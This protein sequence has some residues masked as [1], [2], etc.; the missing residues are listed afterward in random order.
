LYRIPDGIGFSATDLAV[1]SDCAHR[2]ALELRVVGG[3][4]KRPGRNALQEQLLDV[5]GLE[6]EKRALAHLEATYGAAVTIRSGPTSLERAAEETADAMHSGAPLIYQAVF[7]DGKWQGRPDFLVKTP[8]PSKLGAFSYEVVDAKLARELRARSVLQLLVYGT[9]L[10]RVQGTTPARFGVVPMTG[11]LDVEW[12]RT[13]DF[14]AYERRVRTSFEAFVA[15]G[16]GD[17]TYPEPVEHCDVCPW[18]KRCDSRRREDDHLSLVAGMTGRQR[19]RLVDGGVERV[20]ELGALA[21]ELRIEG[22]RTETLARL[23]EQARLQVTGRSAG[24]L[25]YELLLEAEAGTG[26]ESLPERSPGDVFLDLEGDPHLGGKGLDY[27]FGLLE[28][29]EEDDYFGGPPRKGPPK[30]HAFWATT[31]AEERRAFEAVV[32]RMRARFEQYPGLH[33]YHFGHRENDALKRLANRHGTRVDV[34]DDWLSRHTL[35]DLHRAVRQGLRA[36]VESYSLKELEPLWAFERKTEVRDAKWA[37][38]TFTLALETGAPPDDDTE[39]QR[40]LIQSYNRE[41][42]E[43]AMHLRDWLETRRIELAAAS[44]RVLKRPEEPKQKTSDDARDLKLATERVRKALVGDLADDDDGLRARALRLLA[45]LLDWHARESKAEYWEFFRARD[46]ALED[47]LE[48]RSVLANPHLVGEMEQVAQ[49][50]V[51]RYEFPE[52]EHGI[53]VDTSPIDPDREDETFGKVLVVG[54]DHLHVKRGKKRPPT[55]PSR[56]VPPKPLPTTNQRKCLLALGES[57]AE[58]GLDAATDF[59]AARALLCRRPPNGAEGTLVR[60][61]E[62]PQDAV[63]RLARSLR[64]SVLAI[65]GPPGSGKTTCA[66]RTIVALVRDGKRVGVV[67]QSHKV[68]VQLL[69]KADELA[70]A[71]GEPLRVLHVGDEEDRD[72]EDLGFESSK[73]HEQIAA[74]L[75]AGSLYLVG[76]TAWAWTRPDYAGLLDVLCVD[77]AGQVSLA[78]ALAVSRAAESLLLFGDPAQLEQPQKGS[79]PDG[80]EVSALEH[81]LGE[82]VT[83]PDDAGVFLPRTRRLHPSLC[84][85]TS[86]VFYEGR[87]EPVASLD[88]QRVNAAGLFGG[89]GLRFL[90]VLHRGNG[91]SAPEEVDVIRRALDALF[92]GNPSFVDRDGRTRALDR[93]KDV[94][95]VAPYNVQVAAL[96]RALGPMRIGTVDKF[97]GQEAPIVIYSMTSSS[98]EDAPRG[99]EFLYSLDRLNVATS[100]AQALVVLVASPTVFQTRCKTPRQMRLANALCRYLELVSDGEPSSR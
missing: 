84:R 91:N 48:D 34:I 31:P 52:Q 41:D 78:N 85:F 47:R 100:R 24:R 13:A 38:Q 49:S 90:G 40:A 39:R 36:S 19:T 6:H 9:L 56:L 61:G 69:R 15:D 46:V 18:W 23:R 87:L 60:Q 67:A 10:E 89:A 82:H 26:L 28:L 70:R 25:L 50:I 86:E 81:V 83:L 58:H 65:Q 63:V 5:R 51:Y 2:S 29:D 53:R 42:C 20:V 97:Q 3:E 92:A 12:L 99:M 45:S 57:V 71:E 80:A 72:G 17:A 62:D 43:S 54:P 22:L 88:V 11:A 79:H 73:N 76:G 64:H 14:A 35:V 59:G 93:A 30:Y 1:H 77:E 4:L 8:T 75:R 16:A 33:I 74:E 68:I 55:N 37:M 96:R 21:S 66:A 94:L 98:S 7:L 44:G 27:L 95:V 32:D